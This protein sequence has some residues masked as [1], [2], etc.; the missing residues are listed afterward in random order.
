MDRTPDRGVVSFAKSLRGR[1]CKLS[2][3]G[4]Q[5]NKRVVQIGPHPRV[6]LGSSPARPPPAPFASKRSTPVPAERNRPAPSSGRSPR[7]L[8]AHPAFGISL[9]CTPLSNKSGW[10]K[11]SNNV[12]LAA[13]RCNA[14]NPL[15]LLSHDTMHS[16]GLRPTHMPTAFAPFLRW[17]G[18]RRCPR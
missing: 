14:A 6:G 16:Y 3:F 4:L 2:K 10:L 1:A 17:G 18:D 8:P 11:V 9:Y 15:R 12:R 5:P 7:A 13:A